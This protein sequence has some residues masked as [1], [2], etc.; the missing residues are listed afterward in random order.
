[1]T[2]TCPNHECRKQIIFIAFGDMSTA[3][4]S[5]G[6]TFVLDEVEQVS[7]VVPPG[8]ARPPASALVPEKLAEDYDEACLV[9][10]YSAKASAA[11][12]RRCLQ[13]MLR[14][15]AG[16]KPA[17]LVDEID[18]VINSGNL[19]PHIRKS[20]DIV[21]NYGNFAT[22]P[23]DSEKTGELIEVEAGEAEWTLDIIE[24]LFDFYFVQPQ[25]LAEK[26][27]KLEEKLRDS[28]SGKLRG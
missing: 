12:S 23:I 1:M 26:R 17:R 8:A 16:V 18:E 11:L 21:R 2:Y 20:I 15:Y 3:M 13:H 9:L 10:P 19:P 6:P 27:K 14:K 28:G 24:A 5:Y 25:E 4:G 22:H 7:R